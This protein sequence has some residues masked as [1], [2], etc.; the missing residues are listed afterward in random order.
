MG[1][2]ATTLKE[3]RGVSRHTGCQSKTA[4]FEKLGPLLQPHP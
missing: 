4:Q 1:A 3:Y 2:I